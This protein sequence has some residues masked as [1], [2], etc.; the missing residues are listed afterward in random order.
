MKWDRAA[1]GEF[2]LLIVPS[3]DLLIYKIGG[4]NGEY[5]PTLT[6]VPQPG[7]SHARVI[8]GRFREPVY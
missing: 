5:D 2:A 3:L 4:N 1:A 6:D 8:G 7:S